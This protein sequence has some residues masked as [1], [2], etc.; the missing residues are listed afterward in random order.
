MKCEIRFLAVV[1]FLPLCGYAATK[2]P[3]SV[4][5]ASARAADAT[6]SPMFH[7]NPWP[8][9][10]QGR[11]LQGTTLVMGL[12]DPT[13]HMT[14]A[15]INRS[16]GHVSLDRLA[17][18]WLSTQAFKPV[19]RYGFPSAGYVR[20][21]VSFQAGTVPP[22]PFPKTYCQTQPIATLLESLK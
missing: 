16:S 18:R 17:V 3:S 15:C 22:T 21:P 20:V 14:E 19:V 8:L 11:P 1:A 2:P 6:P 4:S 13:G 12:V 9:D 7:G 10:A 5:A